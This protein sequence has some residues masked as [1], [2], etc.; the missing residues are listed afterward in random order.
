[1]KKSRAELETEERLNFIRIYK[2]L[3]FS[4]VFKSIVT[5]KEFDCSYSETLMHEIFLGYYKNA[6]EVK[7]IG[8]RDFLTSFIHSYQYEE[9]EF[10]KHLKL[11]EF[12][13]QKLK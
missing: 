11:I 4:E 12:E 1:M 2:N 9:T 13:L 5:K 7:L 6:T 10:A 3:T 8:M